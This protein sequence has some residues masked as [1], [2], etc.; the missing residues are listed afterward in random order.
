MTKR[1]RDRRNEMSGEQSGGNAQNCENDR[2]DETVSNRSMGK[3]FLDVGADGE[4]NL[5]DYTAGGVE[6]RNL[7][8]DER[9]KKS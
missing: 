1:E 8:T 6:I 4:E 5:P 2:E 3:V 9:E 7:T